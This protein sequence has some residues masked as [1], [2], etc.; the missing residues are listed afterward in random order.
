MGLP[1]TQTELHFCTHLKISVQN[2]KE[3]IYSGKVI[4]EQLLTD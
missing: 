3:K 4:N 1:V 2:K